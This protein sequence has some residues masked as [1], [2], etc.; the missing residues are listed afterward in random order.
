MRPTDPVTVDF[1]THGIEPRPDYPPKPV[2]VAIKYPGKR[3]RYW[4][5]GHA[6]RNNCSLAEGVREVRRAWGWTGGVL[7]HHGKFD[8]EVAEKAFCV[9]RLPWQRY[10]DTLFLLFLN[11]PH[12]PDLGL[13]SSAKLLLGREPEERDLVGSWLLDHQPVS[14]IKVS[15]APKSEHYYMRYVAHAPGDL[16]GRYAVGDVDRAWGLFKLLLPKIDGRAM[17]EAYCRER[18]LLPVLLEMEQAGVRV[19]LDLLRRDLL[20]Y[21]K[22]LGRLDKWLLGELGDINLDSGGQL[23][24]ALVKAKK[25]DL[26][27]LGRTKT[28]KPKSDKEALGQ[29]VTDP[30]LLEALGYR[31]KLSTCL[32]TFMGPWAKTASRSGGLIYTSWHQARHE[33]G[34]RTGRLS[35]TPNFQNIPKKFDAI[36]RY[37]EQGPRL[38]PLPRVRR[39]IVPFEG[40]VLLDRDYSQQELRILGHFE[41]GPLL[42]A[43]QADPWL[44]VHE[45]ARKLI[46]RLTGKDFGRKPIKNTGFAI[47]YGMGV[48]RLALKSEVSFEVAKEVREAYLRIFPGLKAIQW[49]L[50]ARAASKKPLRTWGGREY[51]CEEPRVVDGRLRQFDYKLLN[52]LIQ[53]SAADCTKQALVNLGESMP[54]GCGLL[55]N[56]HDEIL[57]SVPRERVRQSMDWLRAGMEKVS[58]DVPMLSEGSWSGRSWA[59]LRPYD[60]KG[61]MIYDK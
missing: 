37:N 25:V 29:A 50:K 10:H 55:L 36:A 5:W 58:F 47:L 13:K 54:A 16:V 60:E 15:L 26:G 9:K 35:S 22:V 30:R 7:F 42:K 40:Q 33:V 46:N 18:R 31:S 32:Q 43:Y 48:G 11:D 51:Y 20:R 14:G 27:K 52:Y 4:A 8:M 59:D 53:G 61:K 24:G 38:P 23:V 2:G 45:H 41:D 56:A 39:Y 12:Q 21:G 1:E 28:G 19:D 44:D 49:D 17:G 34:A 3:A 6:A 57:V